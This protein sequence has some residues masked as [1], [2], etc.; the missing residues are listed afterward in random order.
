MRLNVYDFDGTIYDGDVTVDFFK[1][2]FFRKPQKL[3][4]LLKLSWFFVLFFLNKITIKDFKETFLAYSVDKNSLETDLKDFWEIHIK[5]IKEFYHSKKDSNDLIISAS[6]QFLLESIS[7]ILGV[8]LISTIYDVNTKKIIGENL[9]GNVKLS[10][11]YK[12]YPDAEI[13]EF[14]SDSMTDTPLAKISNHAF[15][16][17]K[18]TLINWEDA[19]GKTRFSL[20]FKSL[21]FIRF[22]FSGGMGTLANFIVSSLFSFQINPIIS[23]VFGYGSSLFVTFYLSNQIIFKEKLSLNKFIKFTLSYIPNFLILFTFVN[24]F[25]RL[26]NINPIITYAMAAIFGLPITFIL[27]KLFTFDKGEFYE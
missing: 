5:K 17:K 25:I 3:R 19:P 24:I 20:N 8:N 12:R 16:V 13:E 23:Y 1:F 2:M 27:V 14:Y 4:K 22:V 21:D 26:L 9:K 6:P 18:Y 15:F 11:F 7:M 10:R